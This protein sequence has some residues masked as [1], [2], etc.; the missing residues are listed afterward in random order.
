MSRKYVNNTCP[1][2]LKKFKEEDAVVF[3][4]VAKVT[5]TK[6]SSLAV[7]DLQKDECRVLFNSNGSEIVHEKCYPLSIRV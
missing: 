1:V 3:V 6:L 7:R 4:A 2:C 5:Y